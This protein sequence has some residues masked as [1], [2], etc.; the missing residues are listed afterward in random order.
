[1]RPAAQNM[2]AGETTLRHAVYHSPP[3]LQPTAGDGRVAQ[4]SAPAPQQQ[5][6]GAECPKGEVPRNTNGRTTDE[7]PMERG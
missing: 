6:Q 1:M 4:V 3:R 2:T 5:S 7:I